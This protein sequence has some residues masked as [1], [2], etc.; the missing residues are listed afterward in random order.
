M[1]L[2]QLINGWVGIMVGCLRTNRNVN[3]LKSSFLRR[4]KIF[5]VPF[6][7]K[8]PQNYWYLLQAL[9]WIIQNGTNLHLSLILDKL[10]C[11]WSGVEKWPPLNKRGHRK[12]NMAQQSSC[13][14]MLL[15]TSSRTNY[16]VPEQ[17]ILFWNELYCSS[18]TVLVVY[19][20][21]MQRTRVF[22]NP[23]IQ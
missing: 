6:P 17:T 23:N 1:G 16:I 8:E 4:V 5:A 15:D 22:S 10:F 12:W 14:F 2:L 3:Y 9:N 18:T 7:Q 21:V 19:N 11:K 20:K 13:F